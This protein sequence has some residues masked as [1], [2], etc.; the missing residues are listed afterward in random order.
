MTVVDGTLG[1]GGHAEAILKVIGRGGRLIAMDQDPIALKNA[2]EKLK[3]YPQATFHHANFSD[4]DQVLTK[5]NISSVDAV[6][7]DI[8]LSSNQLEDAE[9]GFSFER[10]GPLDM[11]MNP[12]APVS[13]KDLINDLSEEELADLFWRY[14]EER[15]S[16]R[17]AS[18]ICRERKRQSIET[19]TDLAAIIQRA[20]PV[21]KSKPKHRKRIH[22]ATRIFQAL[23]IAVNR[24]LQVLE[25]TLPKIWNCLGK[26]GRLAVI[27]FHSLEDRIVKNI[28]RDWYQSKEALRVTKK[29]I[30]PTREEI[31]ENKRSR[32]AKLRAVEKL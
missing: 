3:N 27:S 30:V 12:E 22:Y 32:S 1:G 28:F 5:L 8:G 17:Y 29:P 4:I 24:E 16:R 14:G 10:E 25:E 6:L 9:R 19:T 23:R 26:G 20:T 11:R 15:R 21:P 13:A 2:K 18:W 31:L 7:L